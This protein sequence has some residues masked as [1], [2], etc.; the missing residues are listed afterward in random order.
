MFVCS[1]GS[2]DARRDP[3]SLLTAIHGG[4]EDLMRPARTETLVRNISI[5]LT[6]NL[7][8]LLEQGRKQ[9]LG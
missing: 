1:E 9:L 5:E 7:E 4:R 2:H 8:V 3:D 6:E